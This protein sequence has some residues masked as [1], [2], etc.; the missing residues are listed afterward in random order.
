MGKSTDTLKG[1]CSQNTLK[2]ERLAHWSYRQERNFIDR[3]KLR[4]QWGPE[5][6]CS[7]SIEVR[8]DIYI[9]FPP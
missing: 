4:G 9:W 6:R 7:P 2:N 5:I 1:S 3:E 8:G